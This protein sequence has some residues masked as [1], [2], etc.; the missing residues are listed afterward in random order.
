MAIQMSNGRVL[1]GKAMKVPTN[2]SLYDKCKI[3]HVLY[4][5]MIVLSLK[6]RIWLGNVDAYV[7][8]LRVLWFF[9]FLYSIWS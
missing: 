2:P 3:G 8:R 4:M 1:G 7:Q 5:F 9:N 6:F